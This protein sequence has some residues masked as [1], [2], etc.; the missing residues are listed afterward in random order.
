MPQIRILQHGTAP[1][2]GHGS[3]KRATFSRRGALG[4]KL[5][6]R[7]SWY[8]CDLTFRQRVGL[9]S[10]HCGVPLSLS[11]GNALLCLDQGCR[12]R[13]EGQQCLEKVVS[14]LTRSANFSRLSQVRTGVQRGGVVHLARAI[15]PPGYPVAR[16]AADRGTGRA[17]WGIWSKCQLLSI[18]SASTRRPVLGTLSSSG[19]P[20][21]VHGDTATQP[22]S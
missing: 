14:G 2:S 22:H 5:K 3:Q 13:W 1:K 16:G 20:S 17:Q 15:R 19:S 21:H 8:A 10:W 18:Q 11:S 7:G 12:G 4:S 6:D 9:G